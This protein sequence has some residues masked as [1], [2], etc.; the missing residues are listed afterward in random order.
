MEQKLA[1][2][3]IARSGDTL[4]SNTFGLLVDKDGQPIHEHNDAGAKSDVKDISNNPDF[5]SLLDVNGKL[6]SITQF[7]SPRPGVAYVSEMEQSSDGE[8][9]LTSTTPIDFSS[10][11]GVWIPCAGSVTPWGTHLGS[12]EYEPDARP[13]DETPDQEAS[14]SVT[15]FLRYFGEY[16]A[17]ATGAETR[18]AGF[19]PYNYGYAWE[20]Q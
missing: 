6:Y 19:F 1:F 16:K 14:G 7:E 10:W 11:G 13:L 9:T 5:T 17:T 15:T 3:T 4:G 8:L 18:T 2:H 12:E 20:A